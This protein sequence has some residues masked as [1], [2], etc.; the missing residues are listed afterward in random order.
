VGASLGLCNRR[1][2]GALLL[3]G[4]EADALICLG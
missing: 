1:L 3:P 4:G 2:R